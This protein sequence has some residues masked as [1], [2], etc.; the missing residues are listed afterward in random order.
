MHENALI[1]RV[2]KGDAKAAETLVTTHYARIYRLLRCLTGSVETA[3]DLTQQTFMRAWQ[4]LASYQGRAAFATW[5]HRIAYHE[6]TH[7]LRARRDHLPLDEAAHIADLKAAHGLDSILV[8]RAL[9]HLAAELRDVFVLYYLQQLSVAEVA[10]VLDMPAG[11]VKSRLFTA[12][13]QM[14]A[15]WEAAEAPTAPLPEEAPARLF[16]SGCNGA[17]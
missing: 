2:L 6:Y 9:M 3:E 7:W 17:G 8:S 14:R 5:L 13:K 1:K 11:T 12:R 10:E 16:V 15:L 4:A